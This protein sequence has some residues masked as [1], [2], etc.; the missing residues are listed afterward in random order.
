MPHEN[1][2]QNLLSFYG[3][4]EV[5]RG[6]LREIRSNHDF[7]VEALSDKKEYA[8]VLYR[9]ISQEI[10]ISSIAENLGLH[11]NTIERWNITGHVPVHYI[12]D[13]KRMLGIGEGQPE[14]QFYTKADVAKNCYKTFLQVADSLKIN[15]KKYKFIEPSAGCG[16]FYQALP[17]TRR[18]GIDL[19]PH[20]PFD[21]EIE[22]GDYLLW[23]PKKQDN[24]IVIG[25]PP[26]GLR[27]H[28][29][30]KF[31]N[32][33]VE[34]SDVI[35]FILPQ[36]FE[37]DGKGVPSKRVD[38]RLKLAY[39]EK[40]PANSFEK[41][42]GTPVDVSTIFQVWTKINHEHITLKPRKSCKEFIRIYSLSDGGTPSSTRNKKMIGNCHVYLPSTCFAGMKAYERFEDLP[43][44]R[45]YGVVIHQSIKE[46]KKILFSHDWIATSFKSTNG[47]MN[48]R[49]SLIENVLTEKGYFDGR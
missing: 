38:K 25:N 23:E 16:W 24:Y 2:N 8:S 46:I 17:K 21:N 29:A 7:N 10:G 13:F 39:S 48:L 5:C 4:D 6:G 20:Y 49:S 36:L 42:D 26:F 19:Q 15:L 1:P 22:K 18:I 12:N 35:A 31:I 47:A 43:N 40:L 14:D 11:T 34:F 30:L 3:A 37:S 45:G 44:Q 27:G 9:K 41:P 28:L 33:S 32:H